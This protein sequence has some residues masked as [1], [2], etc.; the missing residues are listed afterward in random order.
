MAT[1][2]ERFFHASTYSVDAPSKLHQSYVSVIPEAILGVNNSF[3][4]RHRSNYGLI[5][6][7]FSLR[8]EKSTIFKKLDKLV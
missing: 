3:I 8:E 2:L 6:F 5:A 7:F 4:Y 1:L